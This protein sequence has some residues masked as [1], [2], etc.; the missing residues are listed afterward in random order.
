M[1]VANSWQFPGFSTLSVVS[2][3]LDVL[4]NRALANGRHLAD[5]PGPEVMRM[6][7]AVKAALDLA[8]ILNPSIWL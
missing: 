3:V 6:T 8:G 2:R 5:Q 7:R 4:P 1:A